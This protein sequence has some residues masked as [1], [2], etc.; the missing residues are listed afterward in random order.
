MFETT[1]AARMATELRSVS[2]QRENGRC[3]PPALEGSS[4]K[5]SESRR[6]RRIKALLKELN[7]EGIRNRDVLLAIAKVPRER[8][9]PPER[10]ADA[11][12]NRALP[13]GAGQ[14]ISQPFIVALMTQALKLTGRERVLEIG[15]GSGY[16]TAILCELAATVVSIERH[17]ALAASALERLR[18]LGYQNVEVI[19]ADGSQGW[20]DG[21]PYDRIIVTAAAPQ[22]PASLVDQLSPEDGAR[23]VLPVGNLEQQHLLIVERKRGD[24]VIAHLGPV[25][26]VPLIGEAAWKSRPEP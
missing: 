24:L 3:L 10:A 4:P 18:D 26:F 16:Q 5:V 15:T 14:T 1:L 9:V 7:E 17:P 11:W 19:V 2:E 20:A 8:F 13:I 6:V 25:R 22:V 21:A 23:L 12:E